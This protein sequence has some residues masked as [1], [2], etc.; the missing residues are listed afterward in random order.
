MLDKLLW[1]AGILGFTY[2]LLMLIQKGSVKLYQWQQ[3]QKK[4]AVDRLFQQAAEIDYGY[5]VK[6]LKEEYLETR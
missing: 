3:R 4:K 2:L 1:I 5:Y 6:K